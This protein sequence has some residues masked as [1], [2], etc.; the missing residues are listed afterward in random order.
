M[1]KRLIE[2]LK[3]KDVLVQVMYRNKCG[4]QLIDQFFNDSKRQQIVSISEEK[5]KIVITCD[6]SK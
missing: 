6:A 2:I 1:N 3:K 5:G 4:G